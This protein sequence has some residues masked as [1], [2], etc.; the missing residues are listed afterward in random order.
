MD[1][2]KEEKL[3]QETGLKQELPFSLSMSQTGT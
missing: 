2:E 3:N 1:D